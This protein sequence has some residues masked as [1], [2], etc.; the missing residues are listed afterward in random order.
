LPI[1]IIMASVHAACELG[2][3]AIH[4]HDQYEVDEDANVIINVFILN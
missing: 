3:S 2:N 1:N 4:H